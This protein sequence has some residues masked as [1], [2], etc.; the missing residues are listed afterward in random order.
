M[1]KD[2]Q[3]VVVPEKVVIGVM[4]WDEVVKPHPPIQRAL[5]EVVEKLRR[6]GQEGE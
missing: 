2:W 3:D 6:K 1:A 5:K 4:Y